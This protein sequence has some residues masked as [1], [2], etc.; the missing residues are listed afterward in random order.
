MIARLLCRNAVRVSPSFQLPAR[1]LLP[2]RCSTTDVVSVL[3]SRGLVEDA[4]GLEELRE[5]TR[6]KRVKLYCGF[7]PTADSLHLGN[8]LAIVVLTWFQ[9][10][11][12]EPYALIGGAT[13]RVGDPSGKQMERPM[14]TESQLQENSKG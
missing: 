1:S 13:G 3:E 6:E 4:S 8:L 9:R 10:F 5:V 12:H 2:Q 14:L 7:D 11:G